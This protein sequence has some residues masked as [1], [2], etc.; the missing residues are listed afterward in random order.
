MKRRLYFILPD[1]RLARTV[2]NE[3]LLAR[4]PENRMHVIADERIDLEDLPEASLWQRSDLSHGLQL[5]L[6]VGGLTGVVVGVLAVLF[7]WIT[8]GYE[9]KT[10]MA[11]VLA[12]LFVGTWAASMIAVNVPNT[13]HRAFETDLQQEHILFIVDIPVQRVDEITELVT[14]HHPEADMRGIE[15]NIPVFP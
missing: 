5:G 4:V 2:H 10:I 11:T 14:R 8:P 15:P 1:T 3:L 13:R 9:A 7:G 6:P 12:G